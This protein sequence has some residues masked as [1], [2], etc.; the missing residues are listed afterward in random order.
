MIRKKR[1]RDNSAALEE[2]ATTETVERNDGAK[3]PP[4]AGKEQ[5]GVRGGAAE[6]GPVQTRPHPIPRSHRELGTAIFAVA[7]PVKAGSELLQPGEERADP[8]RLNALK[9]F[10]GWVY[11]RPDAQGCYKP[12]RIIWDLP[13]PPYEPADPE[14]DESEGGEA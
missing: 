3:G 13:C 4:K 14:E 10:A 2:G 9:E 11:G 1:F 8:V 6:A 5:P 12:P 7:D